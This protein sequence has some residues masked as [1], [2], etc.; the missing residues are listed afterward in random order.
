MGDRYDKSHYIE[1][2]F[3]VNYERCAFNFFIS[4]SKSER[5]E[6][7]RGFDS[8]Y[9]FFQNMRNSGLLDT[10]KKQV[11][12]IVISNLEKWYEVKPDWEAAVLDF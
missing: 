7:T 3:D 9:G 5:D 8:D 12:P 4:K 2:P 1:L 6:L 11:A 10:L